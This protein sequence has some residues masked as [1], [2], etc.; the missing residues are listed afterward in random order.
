MNRPSPSAVSRVDEGN[1]WHVGWMD[2]WI[3]GW[4]ERVDG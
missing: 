3:V 2:G 4:L 1:G